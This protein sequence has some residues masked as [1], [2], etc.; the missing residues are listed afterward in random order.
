M[1]C[2]HIYLH[3]I[4]TP[5]YMYMYIIVLQDLQV[6]KERASETAVTLEHYKQQNLEFQKQCQALQGEKEAMKAMV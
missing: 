5:M 1:S 3:M 4:D 6:T 2:M